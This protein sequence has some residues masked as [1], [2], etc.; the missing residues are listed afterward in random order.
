MLLVLLLAANLLEM[1]RTRLHRMT[2]RTRSSPYTV[3]TRSQNKGQ[4]TLKEPTSKKDW[5]DATC[6]VCM[7]YPHNAV[8]LLCSSHDKGCRP[9]MCGTGYKFSNCL[10]QF[11]KA[12]ATTSKTPRCYPPTETNVGDCSSELTCPLCRG[13]VKGWTVVDGARE[14]LNT[15]RRGCVQGSCMY[16]GTYEELRRHMRTKHKGAGRQ[17]VDPARRRDWA[18]MEQERERDDVMSTIRSTMPGAIVLGDYVIEHGGGSGAHAYDRDWLDFLLLETARMRRLGRFYHGVG[19]LGGPNLMQRLRSE[20]LLDDDDTHDI[21]DIHDDDDDDDNDDDD[22]G[23]GDNAVGGDDEGDGNSDGGGGYEGGPRFSPI[24]DRER[25]R[26]MVAG[27]S[28]R[29][30]LADLT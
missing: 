30:S 29:R 12:Y 25:R 18:R 9:Y 16:S 21:Y 2:R 20:D 22:D 1:A 6:S 13:Q 8:L 24:N 28:R 17:E 3:M 11:K 5:E 7:E 26:S 27:R 15:K 10:N 14:F 23:D 19:G 4:Q